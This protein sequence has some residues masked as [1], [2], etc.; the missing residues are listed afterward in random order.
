M[1]AITGLL[2][3]IRVGPIGPSPALGA[4]FGA[5]AARA[6]R[7][8]PALKCPPA[9]VSTATANDP[10]FSNPSKAAFSADAVAGSTAFLTS[11][12]VMVTVITA[13]SAVTSTSRAEPG[14]VR[15][16]RVH[17]RIAVVLWW[18]IRLLDGA[19]ADPANQVQERACLVVGA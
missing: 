3:T 16:L 18:R 17:E 8:K 10:S 1:A 15:L 13:P 5:P 9:P 7:S 12:R 19:W 2:R 14:A 11:G 6:F 4:G